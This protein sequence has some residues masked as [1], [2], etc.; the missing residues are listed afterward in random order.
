MTDTEKQRLI[1][2]IVF[3]Y[4]KK[5]KNKEIPLGS[6]VCVGSDLILTA[7]HVVMPDEELLAADKITIAGVDGRLDNTL[8]VKKIIQAGDPKQDIILLQTKAQLANPLLSCAPDSRP[9]SSQAV[10]LI[11]YQGEAV[12]ILPCS[13]SQ[14][15]GETGCY[16][17]SPYPAKGMSGGAVLVDGKLIGLIN[18]RNTDS[19]CGYLL[20]LADCRDFIAANIPVSGSVQSMDTPQSGSD[21]TLNG[22]DSSQNISAQFSMEI[23]GITQEEAQ[24]FLP[25]RVDIYISYT[26]SSDTDDAI[27]QN[28]YRACQEHPRL[29]PHIDNRELAEGDSI[30]QYMDV[31]SAARFVVCLFSE[32]YFLSPNCVLE[33]AG[34]YHNQYMRH[35]VFPLFVNYFFNDDKRQKMML[36]KVDDENLQSRVRKKTGHALS[37]LLHQSMTDYMDG[38]AGTVQKGAAEHQADHF[39]GFIDSFLATIIAHNKE[40]FKAHKEK[41]VSQVSGRL[42][43]P[44]C[45]P[46][47]PHLAY[48]LQCDAS[49]NNCAAALFAADACAGLA[50]L[51]AAVK[52]TGLDFRSSRILEEIAGYILLSAIEPGWWLINEFRLQRAITT[53]SRLDAAE[54]YSH[55]IEIVLARISDRPPMYQRN[56]VTINSRCQVNEAQGIN[57]TQDTGVIK[58]SYLWAFYEDITKV[59]VGHSRGDADRILPELRGLLKIKLREHKQFFYIIRQEDYDS[60]VKKGVIEEIHNALDN[61]LQFVVLGSSPTAQNNCNVLSVDS[62]EILGYISKIL[63]SM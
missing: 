50:A 4:Q 11:G 39:K 54:L 58:Q 61:M 3:L 2:A 31:L 15:D 17:F 55:E 60:L 23:P 10:T 49:A 47:L 29:Q 5:E 1:R 8:A 36:A 33:F 32:D 35:R 18:A 56:G 52:D 59:P 46:L 62:E 7:R 24:Q 43:H 22:S 57:F 13:I 27:A 14:Q 19:N 38:F 20:A 53:G 48:A 30:Y 63:G 44:A 26:R 28:F 41:L 37:D 34:L 21:N 45:A 6:G 9:S 51:I 40:R 16:A 42:Q 12:A 25:D